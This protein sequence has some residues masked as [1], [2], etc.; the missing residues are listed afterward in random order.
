SPAIGRLALRPAIP[1]RAT[2]PTPQFFDPLLDV[3]VG[4]F[5]L[6]D[7]AVALEGLVGDVLFLEGPA[8][9]VAHELG[10]VVVL[11]RIVVD[12]AL[13]GFDRLIDEAGLEEGAA[14]G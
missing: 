8:L 13:K 7:L 2:L 10:P 6:G 4:E 5:G 9:P 1:E 3:L 12:D 14:E 11:E